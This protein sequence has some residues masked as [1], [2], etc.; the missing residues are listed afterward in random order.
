MRAIH[1]CATAETTSAVTVR[2]ST[3]P[4]T[5]KLHIVLQQSQ[6]EDYTHLSTGHVS[7]RVRMV[8]LPPSH[9]K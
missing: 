5:P 2:R 3:S 1:P 7:S 9:V 6:E 4:L 8:A